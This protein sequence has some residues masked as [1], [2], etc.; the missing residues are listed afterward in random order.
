MPATARR[1]ALIAFD[2]TAARLR[3]LIRPALK[4]DASV[5]LV[6]DSEGNSLPDDVEVQPLSAMDEV[7]QWAD[8]VAVDVGR[9][10]LPGLRKR[11]TQRNQIAAVRDAQVLIRTPMPCGGIAEC[12]VCAVTTKSSWKMSCKDGP[13]FDWKEI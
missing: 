1:I 7:L 10:N 5:V 9:E 12:G 3:G 13:V 6:T 11:L 2:D 8:Y 4:Q